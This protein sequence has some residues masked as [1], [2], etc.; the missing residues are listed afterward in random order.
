MTKILLAAALS[1]VAFSASA[2]QPSQFTIVVSEQ[3]LNLIGVALGKLPYEAVH[4]TIDH[5]M[6][7]V[8]AQQAAAKSRKLSGEGTKP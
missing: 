2:Q 8:K 1:V 7:Q 3:Q 6:L 4:D 5:I